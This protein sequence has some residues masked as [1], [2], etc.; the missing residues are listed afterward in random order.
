LW[1]LDPARL[2][3]QSL[4]I[5]KPF[6]AVY[7]KYRL[8][9]FGFGASSD[10][11]EAQ[12]DFSFKGCNFG[13]RDQHVA[14]RWV[15]QNISA[16]GGDPE[17]ITVGGQSAGGN[18]VHALV[19]EAKQNPGKPLFQRAIIQ[20]GAMGTVG[21]I[22]IAEADQRWKSLYEHVQVT[23]RTP[24]EQVDFLRDMSEADLVRAAGELGWFSFPLVTENKTLTETPNGQWRLVLEPRS[25]YGSLDSIEGSIDILIGDCDAEVRAPFL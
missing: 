18:S 19:L 5:G 13:L 25:D 23:Q 15:S 1:T 3:L 21:P 24:K 2:V 16:F 17:R 14:L 9:L 11:L 20:S 6:I 12:P 4:K 7:I 10:I 22:S 8:N